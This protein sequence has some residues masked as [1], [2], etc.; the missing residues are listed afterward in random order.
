M[1]D[2]FMIL[3]NNLDKLF[4]LLF[5]IIAELLA[6]IHIYS[7]PKYIINYV[8][9]VFEKKIAETMTQIR[10]FI[11]SVILESP[12]AGSGLKVGDILL[13]VNDVNIQEAEHHEV[14]SLMQKG[15]QEFVCLGLTTLLNI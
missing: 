12:A 13:A 8:N 9:I 11:C 6:K 1:C 15:E 10:L 4:M 2:S 3:N 5:L 7:F 14:V